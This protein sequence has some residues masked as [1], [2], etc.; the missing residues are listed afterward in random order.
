MLLRLLLLLLHRKE[1]EVIGPTLCPDPGFCKSGS[2]PRTR[3][4]VPSILLQ[5]RQGDWD[6]RHWLKTGR[7]LFAI[8]PFFPSPRK[9][10][11]AVSAR[12]FQLCHPGLSY[13]CHRR[14]R[15]RRQLPKDSFLQTNTHRHPHHARYTYLQDDLRH[16]SP[17][18]HTQHTTPTN[19]EPPQLLHRDW[20]DRR[21]HFLPIPSDRIS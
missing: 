20:P 17:M 7:P 16:F 14:R 18:S 12:V 6:C 4:L 9:S 2:P 11:L 3:S 21:S 5:Q 8:F 15:C 1:I 19:S 13:Q 10:S